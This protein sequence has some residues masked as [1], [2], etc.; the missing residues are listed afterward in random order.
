MLAVL[1]VVKD[2]L[3]SSWLVNHRRIL[4]ILAAGFLMPSVYV[5]LY[6]QP[7]G[8]PRGGVAWL[9]REVQCPDAAV[10]RGARLG[11]RAPG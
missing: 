8:G 1:A 11:V 2:S 9:L 6:L 10:G 3:Q 7:Y 4:V 5:E